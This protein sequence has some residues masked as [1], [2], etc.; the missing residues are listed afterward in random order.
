MMSYSQ[1]YCQFI[2]SIPKLRDEIN[3]C[4][5]IEE[6]WGLWLGALNQK[7]SKEKINNQFD[8]FCQEVRDSLQSDSGILNHKY[9]IRE[10]LQLALDGQNE[11]ALAV[12]N[13]A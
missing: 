3:K 11:R 10:G 1:K 7:G 9:H 5:A 8:Q 12:L 13:R 6:R 4:S 2:G